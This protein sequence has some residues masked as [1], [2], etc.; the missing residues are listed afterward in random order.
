MRPKTDPNPFLEATASQMLAVA[1]ARFP[2]RDAIVA[3]D[4]RGIGNMNALRRWSLHS[5]PPSP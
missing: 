5:S 4:E 1:A 2:D 3:A